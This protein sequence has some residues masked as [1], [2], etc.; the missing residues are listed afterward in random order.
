LELADSVARLTASEQRY[1]T[2][3]E[4]ANDYIAVLTPDGVVREMNRRWVELTQL[5]HEELAGRHIREFAP[6]GRAD[7]LELLEDLIA[8]KAASAAP[9]EIAA[10]DGTV[11][12]M[13]FSATHVDVAGE[14]LVFATGRDVTQHH[15]LEEQLR[16]AQKLEA[17]GQL[18]GGVA[19]DFN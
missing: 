18:A 4:H 14:R 19:H 5:S 8:G 1:R 10:P 15:L 7:A 17:V 3:L 11:V 9:V 16:Q 13:E 6:V 2:L 12:L